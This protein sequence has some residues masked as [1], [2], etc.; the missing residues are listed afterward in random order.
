MIK[1]DITTFIAIYAF[2]SVI[3]IFIVW[4]IFGYKEMK[5]VAPKYTDYVWKCQVCTHT[6]IDSKHVDMSICPVCG[7]YNKRDDSVVG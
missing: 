6:Y 7:S 2:F 5:K 4:I 1:L 3:V